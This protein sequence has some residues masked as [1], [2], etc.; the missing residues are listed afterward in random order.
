MKTPVIDNSRGPSPAADGEVSSNIQTQP[1]KAGRNR[2]RIT[3]AILTII[4]VAAAVVYLK[5]LN[6]ARFGGYH[7]DGI[8]V[9]TAKAIA[10]GQGYRI[11]S[12]PYSPAETKYPPLYPFLLS[13]IWNVNPNF[14]QN[15]TP[16]TLLSIAATLGFLALAY[17]Y[18]VE[19]H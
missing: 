17:R 4:L 1:E 5:T 12:L 15:L 9:T 8:Y 16:M 14:P 10:T 18:L 11:I 7:D 19:H 13:L 2:S 3:A 6:R